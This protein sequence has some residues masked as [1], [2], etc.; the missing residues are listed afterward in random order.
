MKGTKKQE[1]EELSQEESWWKLKWHGI[2][3]GKRLLRDGVGDT[4]CPGKWWKLPGVLG[5]TQKGQGERGNSHHSSPLNLLWALLSFIL[6]LQTWGSCLAGPGGDCGGDLKL[7]SSRALREKKKKKLHFS[8]DFSAQERTVCFHSMYSKVKP[9]HRNSPYILLFFLV[10]PTST[11][12]KKPPQKLT[13]PLVNSVT[14]KSL[15]IC[16]VPAN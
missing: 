16:F 8:W 2:K 3:V 1:T 7:P 10:F 11:V 5:F 15:K 12:F 13:L 9:I 6:L 14:V 4:E